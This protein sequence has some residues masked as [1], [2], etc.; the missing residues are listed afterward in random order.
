MKL[1]FGIFALLAVLVGANV[2]G[3]ERAEAQLLGF[4]P[5]MFQNRA[6]LDAPAA[7]SYTGPGD[8]IS[9][10]TAFYSCARAY[11]AAYATQPATC[12]SLPMR[13]PA[14]PRPVRSL[15]PRPASSISPGRIVE[16]Q[17]RRHSASHTRPALSRR[18]M[19]RR[20]ATNALR[21]RPRAM[22]FRLLWQT[23]PRSRS[24]RSTVC[25][26]SRWVRRL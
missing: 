7:P 24:A 26:A 23:C 1:R 12:A 6:A 3:V 5:G 25:H 14:T 16:G 2:G 21:L 13:R 15:Q 22:W 4:P 10:A 9:G 19:T 18:C 8:V 11:N 17:P 20:P